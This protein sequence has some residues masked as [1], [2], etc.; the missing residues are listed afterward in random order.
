MTSASTP[1]THY[2]NHVSNL[3]HVNI[4]SSPKGNL[5]VKFKCFRSFSFR[6]TLTVRQCLNFLIIFD[7]DVTE[8]TLII[9][10]I[11]IIYCVQFFNK[12]GEFEFCP[13]CVS[14]C[15][16]PDLNINLSD[17]RMVWEVS[18]QLIVLPVQLLV[19]WP[20]PPGAGALNNL[21]VG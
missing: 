1:G 20:W 7:F 6:H 8:L 4:L 14:E 10:C 18:R 5:N 2:L 3:A 11:R 19:F 15:D 9:I 21:M 12:N 13:P 17:P 16:P